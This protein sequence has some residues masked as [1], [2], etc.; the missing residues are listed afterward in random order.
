MFKS[1]LARA[2]GVS[3]WTLARWLKQPYMQE[4]LA[5]FNLRKQQQKLPGK[6]VKIICDEYVIDIE[7]N[8]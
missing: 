5:P 4:V 2:A 8:T 7:E 3:R 1:E 6:V